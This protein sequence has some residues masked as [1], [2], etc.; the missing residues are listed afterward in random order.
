MALKQQAMAVGL[1]LAVIMFC[2][3]K[4]NVLNK[5]T[6]DAN[7][8]ILEHKKRDKKVN[9]QKGSFTHVPDKKGRS[10]RGGGI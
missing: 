2:Y 1:Y 5:E 7:K 4:K 6:Y 9:L 3:G 10:K 8:A